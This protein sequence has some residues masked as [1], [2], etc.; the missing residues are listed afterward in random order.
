MARLKTDGDIAPQ[1]Q[2]GDRKSGRIEA[3]AGFTAWSKRRLTL[4]VPNGG[5][6]QA[7]TVFP[8]TLLAD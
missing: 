5:L 7:A 6:S 4:R 1:P 2:G 8:P 3:E